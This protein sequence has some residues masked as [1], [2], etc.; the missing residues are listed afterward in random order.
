MGHENITEFIL[1][2][3]FSDEDEKV[4]CFVVF[5]L[6]YIAIL[7]GNLFILHTIRG[8]RLR[9]QPMYFFLS[10][11]SFMDVC[12]TS[13]VAPKLITDLLAQ[14]KTISYNSCIAQMFYAHFFGATEIFILVAMAFDRYAAI[15]RPLHYMVIMKRQVCYVLV[16]ASVL[17][18][19]IHSV[20]QVLI[21]IELPFCG[22]NQIDHYFCDVFPLLKL[23][24]TDTSL[25]VIVIISTTGVLSILTFVA[26]VISYIIILSTLRTRSSEGCHKALS[27]C[28]SHITVVFMFFLPLIFT[29]VP[30]AD[31]INNDKVFAL[32]YTMIAPMFNPLVYTLRNTDMKNAMRKMWCRDTRFEGK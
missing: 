19:F 27:T 14:R 23:A 24:C 13:T 2:G 26:L 28:G 17:G 9:E 5:S 20:L 4:A 21:I 30:T 8:S 18:A 11:L 31:S 1:L 12:F 16:M 29:Y 32:F 6:C 3:L 25:L 7:S 15:C 10:Y 22:P